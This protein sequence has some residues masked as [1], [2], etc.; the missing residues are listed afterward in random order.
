MS[1]HTKPDQPSTSEYFMDFSTILTGLVIGFSIAAPVG[2]IGVLCIRRTL[3]DGRKIGLLTGLGAA[4]A[5]AFYG[6]VAGLGLT[7]LTTLLVDAQ[8]W[9]Q[10]SGGIFLLYLGIR[11]FLSHPSQAAAQPQRAGLS[12]YTS[13]LF[14][15][16]T[17]PVTI[18]SF[19]G[20][21]AGLNL[22]MDRLTPGA[23]VLFITGVFLG[24]A[25]W[26]LFLSWLVNLMRDRLPPT[27]LQWVNRLSGLVLG[28]FGLIS[29]GKVIF[30]LA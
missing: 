14:L 5:D 2:P 3:A 9:L 8:T 13:A 28:C 22:G 27:L 4:S 26:W 19:I 15:T 29:L 24:S 10:L 17:N 30:P 1:C 20:I 18:L 16:L 11:T 7:A 21:M 23:P 12:A 6:L 25:A